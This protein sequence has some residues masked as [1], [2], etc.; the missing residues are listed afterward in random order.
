MLS[1]LKSSYAACWTRASVS[2]CEIRKKANNTNVRRGE[3]VVN[4]VSCKT[5]QILHIISM[6]ESIDGVRGARTDAFPIRVIFW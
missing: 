5:Q 3:A 2:F 4:A 6:R 1:G